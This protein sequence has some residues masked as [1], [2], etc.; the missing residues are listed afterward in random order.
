M[1]YEG[2]AV[3]PLG[4]GTLNAAYAEQEIDELLSALGEIDCYDDRKRQWP[5]GR[6]LEHAKSLVAGLNGSELVQLLDL[7][8]E[9]AKL[10]DRRNALVHNAIYS[11]TKV[12]VS[13]VSG[14][15][16]SVSADA[17]TELAT[18]L[19]NFRH[20]LRSLRQRIFKPWLVKQGCRTLAQRLRTDGKRTFSSNRLK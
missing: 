19:S 6:R 15:E 12:V 13:R 18:L 3:R 9:A 8:D 4:L 20:R 5:V 10:F 14:S 16:Q 7:I 2:D 11:G 17:L 1:T